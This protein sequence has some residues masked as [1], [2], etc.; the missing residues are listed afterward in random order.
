M[1]TDSTKLAITLILSLLVIACNDTAGNNT[2][3]VENANVVEI[4]NI[5]QGKGML[6]C[7]EMEIDSRQHLRADVERMD[8]DE[9]NVFSSYQLVM[10]DG[11]FRPE[12]DGVFAGVYRND[13]TAPFSGALGFMS[14]STTERS[15]RLYAFVN[16]VDKTGEILPGSYLEA[17]P[18]EPNFIPVNIEKPLST[19]FYLTIVAV[20]S[21]SHKSFYGLGASFVTHFVFLSDLGGAPEVVEDVYAG[22]IATH[23]AEPNYIAYLADPANPGALD[24][25]VVAG[26]GPYAGVV[27]FDAENNRLMPLKCG[28]QERE[29]IVFQPNL[30]QETR[31]ECSYPVG[32]FD[33]ENIVFLVQGDFFNFGGENVFWRA[34]KID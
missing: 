7:P 34:A 11:E 6:A 31:L 19:G 27:A 21:T 28:R 5:V 20:E 8:T 25:T 4:V 15:Y 23:S 12:V 2:G 3:A 22:E 17:R 9:N 13:S 1:K 29:I 26:F 18:R 30:E 24:L 16:G 32:E 14:S 33:F 10:C